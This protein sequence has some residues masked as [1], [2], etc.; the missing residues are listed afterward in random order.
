LF[1]A[2]SEFI[3]A[4]LVEQGF[5][6]D[7]I[8]VHYIGVDTER[9][10]P[11]PTVPREPVILFVGRL[12]EKK[13]CEYIIR[14]MS[15]IQTEVPDAELV[16]IGDGPLRAELEELATT[17]LHRYQFLGLQPPD[18]VRTWMNRA[19][20]LAAPSVTSSTGDSEGLPMVIVE[21]QAM[22]LPVV[23]SIHAGIPEAVVHEETG[24]LVAERD[25]KGLAEHSL[26]LLKEPNLWQRLSLNGMERSRTKFDLHKQNRALEDI[27][28]RIQLTVGCVNGV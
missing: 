11:D 21:A 25:W 22:G 4:K 16:I 23:S 28:S 18:I 19:C 6:A 10:Q 7:K 12:A 3:K 1:I 24:F 15:Q 13:G 20:L 8:V 17:L 9:F 26:R 14:A 5:P 27:Y 2:V